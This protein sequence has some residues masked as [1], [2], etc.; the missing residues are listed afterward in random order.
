[1][2]ASFFDGGVTLP[3]YVFS[4]IRRGINPEI[5]ATGTAVMVFSRPC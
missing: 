1:V 4:S 3:I 2:I 5:D